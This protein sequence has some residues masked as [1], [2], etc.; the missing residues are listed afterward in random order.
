MEGEEAGEWFPE[1]GPV[2]FDGGGQLGPSP[3]Y[4][5]IDIVQIDEGLFSEV[6]GGCRVLTRP[7]E[8]I[9]EDV[10]GILVV[11]HG[12]VMF[13]NASW[14]VRDSTFWDRSLV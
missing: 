14:R 12:G 13:L 8:S 2:L 10:C 5:K 9:V 6:R 3:A 1:P 4:L 7:E 11:A